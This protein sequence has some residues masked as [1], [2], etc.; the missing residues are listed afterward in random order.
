MIG[1]GIEFS[2]FNDGLLYSGLI[3]F[4]VVYTMIHPIIQHEPDK[5]IRLPF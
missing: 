4:Y 2:C 5:T 3:L 1:S